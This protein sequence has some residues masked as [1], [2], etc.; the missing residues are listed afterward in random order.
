MK[1]VYDKLL[2]HIKSFGGKTKVI[3]NGMEPHQRVGMAMSATG[4]GLGVANYRNNQKKIEL[5]ARKQ[6]IDAKS[7][8]ALQ[9]IHKVLT[10]KPPQ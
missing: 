7:L 1:S 9:K 6:D 5:D 8:A 3:Y 4:L 10:V 2:T